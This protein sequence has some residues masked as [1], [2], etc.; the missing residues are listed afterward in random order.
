MFLTSVSIVIFFVRND[1]EDSRWV[2]VVA[3]VASII[4]FGYVGYLTWENYSLLSGP[5][6]T[7]R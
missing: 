1:D 5:S 4:A 7:A 2:T 3:P 6:T